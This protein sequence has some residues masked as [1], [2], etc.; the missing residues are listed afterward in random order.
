MK[1]KKDNYVVEAKV[2]NAT[3]YFWRLEYNQDL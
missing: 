2:Q 3:L 1:K